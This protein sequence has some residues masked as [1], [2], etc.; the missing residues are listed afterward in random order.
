MGEGSW[1]GMEAKSHRGERYKRNTRRSTSNV[2]SVPLAIKTPE[3]RSQSPEADSAS[4]ELALLKLAAGATARSRRAQH[5]GS[6]RRG[7][8]AAAQPEEEEPGLEDPK[9]SLPLWPPA[10][11]GRGEQGLAG[12]VC[13][14]AGAG[15]AEGGGPPPGAAECGGSFQ[16]VSGRH[17]AAY[18]GRWRR[19]C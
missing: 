18:P 8:A 15:C 4:R 17:G 16:S 9:E 7:R 5:P 3:T 10:F 13:R 14:D 11:A 19:R 1:E 6:G 12:G 2:S